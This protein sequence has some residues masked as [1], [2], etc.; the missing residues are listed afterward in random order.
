MTPD[1]ETRKKL[2]TERR[3]NQILD[4]A[5]E[6]FANKGFSAATIPAIAK[7]AGLAAGTIYI[8]YPSKRVLFIA[9]IESFMI[10]PLSN[11]FRQAASEEFQVTLKE[12]IK[13]RVKFLEG[14]NLSRL[15]SLIGEIQRDPELKTLYI[16]RVFQPFI[17]FMESFYT[18]QINS[19][20]FRQLEP[21]LAVRFVASLIVGMTILISLEGDSSPFNKITNERLTSELM[22]FILNGLMNW[23]KTNQA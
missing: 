16:N 17:G 5:M 7:T 12:A 18:K 4:A 8:Y 23:E 11:I 2:L 9:V 1:R 20:R 15:T 13:D 22:N 19:G 10:S 14:G 3:K 6:V 21:A